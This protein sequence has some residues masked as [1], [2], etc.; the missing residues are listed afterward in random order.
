MV[1]ILRFNQRASVKKEIKRCGAGGNLLAVHVCDWKTP[2][3]DLLLD[4]GVMGEGCIPLKEIRRWVEAAGFD[5]P[6]EVE[7]FSS[8][9]WAEDQ[10]DY[11][12]RVVQA[13]REHC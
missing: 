9:Y 6:H 5:G 10:Q 12:K 4:R 11:L 1:P 2:T 8:T 3:S 13:Y 7:I